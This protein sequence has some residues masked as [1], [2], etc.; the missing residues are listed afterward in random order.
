M[1]TMDWKENTL[2]K[3]GDLPRLMGRRIVRILSQIILPCRTTL[4]SEM[5]SLLFTSIHRKIALIHIIAII[6]IL[7][8][9]VLPCQPSESSQD[10]VAVSQSGLDPS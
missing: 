9:E 7:S 10:A 4:A 1:T 2:H 3:H 8:I 5:P 6:M